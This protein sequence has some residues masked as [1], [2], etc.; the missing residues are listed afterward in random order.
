[1]SA[2]LVFLPADKNDADWVIQCDFD[3][4]ISVDDVTDALLERFARPGWQ[5]IEAEWEAGR[6]GSG[7]CMKRQVGLLDV[8]S[9]ELDEFLAGVAIDP[10]FAA[11]VNAA[12]R[13]GVAVEVVS[14]GIDRAIHTVLASNHLG[15]LSVRANH[16]VQ[17]DERRWRLTSPNASS[18]CVSACGTCKCE[19][20]AQHTA[21]SRKVLF[22]GDGRSDFCVADKAELVLAKAR[23]LE[24]CILHGI[25]H[26]PFR[27]FEDGLALMVSAVDRSRANV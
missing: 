7:E 15:G 2:P 13:L 19:L 23:L 1:M 3:G 14:D 20:L 18:A 26:A 22:V 27:G 11:F 12:K 4:T 24:H 8:S 6:I 25:A 16:L 5:E 21:A 9:G 10:H 17:V